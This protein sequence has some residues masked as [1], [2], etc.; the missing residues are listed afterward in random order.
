MKVLEDKYYIKSESYSHNH[1]MKKNLLK[2]ISTLWAT[3]IKF[4]S[5]QHLHLEKTSD[6]GNISAFLS[7]NS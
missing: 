1:F 6:P 2:I 4:W 7:R 5:Q 3:V